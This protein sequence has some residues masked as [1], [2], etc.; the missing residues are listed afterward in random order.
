[1]PRGSQSL[2]RKKREGRMSS[3]ETSAQVEAGGKPEHAQ[4][5]AG[6]GLVGGLGE[7]RTEEV[8]LANR[9]QQFAGEAKMKNQSK[10]EEMM[11][12]I[13]ESKHQM[14]TKIEKK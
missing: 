2:K 6:R 7:R 3:T 14:K 9:T 12:V 13:Q 10:H 8:S 5:G 4:P 1:M 11:I